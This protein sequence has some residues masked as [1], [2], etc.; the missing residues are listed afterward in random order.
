MEGLSLK[1]VIFDFD[2]TMVDTEVAWYKKAKQLKVF[3]TTEVSSF[4]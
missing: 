3:S 1:A 2:G 4:V